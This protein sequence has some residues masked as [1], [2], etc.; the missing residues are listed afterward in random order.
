MVELVDY[1][2]DG[3]A[4]VQQ[5][6]DTSHHAVHLWQHS[7]LSETEHNLLKPQKAVGSAALSS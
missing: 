6:T 1:T 2:Y 3:Q 7:F 4:C 5:F